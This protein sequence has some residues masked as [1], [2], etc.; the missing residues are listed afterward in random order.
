MENKKM[1]ILINIIY[2]SNIYG[3]SV[4]LRMSKK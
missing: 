4:N 3:D 1:L 2:F